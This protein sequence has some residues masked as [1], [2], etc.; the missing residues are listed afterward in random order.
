MKYIMPPEALWVRLDPAMCPLPLMK[1]A[2]SWARQKPC[3][4]RHLTPLHPPVSPGWGQAGSMI[5][6]APQEGLAPFHKSVVSASSWQPSVCGS[7]FAYPIR[8]LPVPSPAEPYRT[9]RLSLTPSCTGPRQPQCRTWRPPCKHP[10]W[11]M[12][13]APRPSRGGEGAQGL[14]LRRRL[15]GSLAALQGQPSWG[16]ERMEELPSPSLTSVL[17]AAPM[18]PAWT[19]HR[20]QTGCPST[21]VGSSCFW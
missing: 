16:A 18:S 9:Q 20:S 19:G 3:E 14:W 5:A 4:P 2:R 21:G 13:Q 1:T 11:G 7:E 15:L 17:A 8:H 10:D 12:L 6:E